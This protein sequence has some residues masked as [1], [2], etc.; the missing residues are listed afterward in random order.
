MVKV[1]RRIDHARRG[2][3]PRNLSLHWQPF[4]PLPGTPAQWLPAGRGAR[5]MLAPFEGLKTQFCVVRNLAGRTDRTALI[6]SALARSDN[7]A[8]NLL[9]AYADDPG[10]PVELAQQLCG[11]GNADDFLGKR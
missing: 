8:V 2:M 4:Q 7:R 3:T 9:E 11:A 10:L 5:K 1:I 6:C